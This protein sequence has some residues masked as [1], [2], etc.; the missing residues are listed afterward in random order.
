MIEQN[1]SWYIIVNPQDEQKKTCVKLTCLGT[2]CCYVEEQNL[3][4]KVALILLDGNLN[5]NQQHQP[6]KN[7]SVT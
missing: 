4:F 2:Q 6:L 7:A 5:F 1:I 3:L